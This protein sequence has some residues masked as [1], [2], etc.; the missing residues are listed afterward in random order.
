[1]DVDVPL[2][3]RD[4]LPLRGNSIYVRFA[5]IRYIST[6]VEIRYDIKPAC[7][8]EHIESKT[9]RTFEEDISKSRQALYRC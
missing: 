5:H 6:V 3:R 7:S 9:Y 8:A 4:I 1:M 2:A